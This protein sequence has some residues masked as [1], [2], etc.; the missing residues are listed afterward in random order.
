MSPV[1]S[2]EM[3]R[4]LVVLAAV[5]AFVV[6]A[7][8]ASRRKR[9]VAVETECAANP[10]R[11]RFGVAG[12]VLIAFVFLLDRE[13]KRQPLGGLRGD[14]TITAVSGA[15]PKGV[16]QKLQ[17][18]CAVHASG[19]VTAPKVLREAIVDLVPGSPVEI[20]FDDL[21]VVVS[22]WNSYGDLFDTG[23]DVTIR[24]PSHLNMSRYSTALSSRETR[25]RDE[26]A[27]VTV[28]G[29]R[30]FE[31]LSFHPE[32]QYGHGLRAGSNAQLVFLM[33]RLGPEDSLTKIPAKD[34][35]EAIAS[36][37]RAGASSW[38]HAWPSR[39]PSHAALSPFARLF[40]EVDP[41]GGV[42]LFVGLWFMIVGQRIFV[43]LAGVAFGA[44]AV[45]SL[46]ARLDVAR[47]VEAL[48]SANPMQRIEAASQLSMQSA[49]A[50]AAG[51]ALAD[52]FDAESDDDVKAA[53]VLAAGQ[54]PTVV[55]LSKE[56]SSLLVDLDR[57]KGTTPIDAAVRR[58]FEAVTREAIEGA[59]RRAESGF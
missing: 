31:V 33:R 48:H 2:I 54:N 57:R 8:V 1:R 25:V 3:L 55:L 17:F 6:W 59:L 30:P 40:T 27:F 12:A 47:N 16:A 43:G 35:G 53:I 7:F 15:E 38:G 42:I 26:R 24:D 28:A 4:V 37:W 32:V 50:V 20:R 5:L 10:W 46:A 52:R 18:V 36:A 45:L 44:A 23:L 22:A 14:D 41:L 21:G 13:W 49:F 11:R 29:D 56:L 34:V 9:R 19:F 58:T 51:K 39:H